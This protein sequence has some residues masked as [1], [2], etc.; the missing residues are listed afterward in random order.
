MID[1]IT[2]WRRSEAAVWTDWIVTCIAC[3]VLTIA[4]LLA[5]LHWAIIAGLA[6]VTLVFCGALWLIWSVRNDLGDRDDRA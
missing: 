2:A 4:A 1:P 6:L 3:A 5:G